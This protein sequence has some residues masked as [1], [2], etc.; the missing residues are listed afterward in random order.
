[1]IGLR[2]SALV[3]PSVVLMV[4]LSTESTTS[5]AQEP[6]LVPQLA[7]PAFDS[8]SLAASIMAELREE[9]L[10]KALELLGDFPTP[11][12]D[13]VAADKRLPAVAGAIARGLSQLDTDEQYELLHDWTIP[14]EEGGAIKVLTSIVPETSPPWEF[15]RALGQRP[16]KDSFVVSKVGDMPGLFCTAWTMIV[17]ADD[18][19]TLRQLTTELEDLAGKK[20]ENADYVLTL[21]KLRDSRTETEELVKRLEPRVNGGDGVPQPLN[22]SDA[23][24]IAAAA[25][26][27]GVGSVCEEIA[28][29]LNSFQSINGQSELVPFLRRL[30][31]H[32][33]LKSR[34]PETDPKDLFYT[35]PQLWISAND[36]RAGGK[37][38]GADES[39][40][41]THEDHVKRLAGPGDDLLLLRYPLTGTFELKGEVAELE[42]GGGGLTYGGLAFDASNKA[43]T[44]MEAQRGHSVDRV[45]PFVAPKEHRMFNRVNLRSDGDS[46][47]FLSNLHPGFTTTV[48]ACS[49][50]PWLG[51]RAFGYGRIIFRNLELIG[52]PTIPREVRLISK[53]DLRGWTSSYEEATPKFVKPFPT[54]TDDAPTEAPVWTCA[55]GVISGK[56]SE[57]SDADEVIQSHLAYIRPCLSGETVSYEFFYE[58]GQTTVHPALGRLAFLMQAD[59]VRLHWMTNNEVEWTALEADN[60]VIEPLNRRGPRTLPLKSGEWNSVTLQL[61]EGKVNIAL[62]GEEIYER[63]LDDFTGRHFG[64]YHD[65]NKSAVQVRK[66]VLTGDWPEILTAEQLKQLVAFA[67]E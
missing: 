52:E 38:T 31:A 25:E 27:D 19:G 54:R 44:L 34:S 17:A 33:I 64:L 2:R 65:R 14:D 50:S 29:R 13:S 67:G 23:V 66:I 47:T 15:A 26:R 48:E 9:N 39:I 10:E 59:G 16:K 60:S 20:V 24:L 7:A 58:E 43:F 18:A 32:V 30:R 36:Q 57:G 62:N 37:T 35:T 28:E 56:S 45:W 41:L 55:D 22:H 53:T 1:M 21:A 63:S 5:Q 8:T 61:T 46:M 42:H 11:A 4:C 12:S 3:L 51:L 6:V 49:S 40:W